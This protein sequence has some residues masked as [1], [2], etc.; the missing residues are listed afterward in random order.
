MGPQ[1][2]QDAVSKPTNTELNHGDVFLPRGR[3]SPCSETAQGQLIAFQLRLHSFLTS[4]I[5][6]GH[7]FSGCIFQRIGQ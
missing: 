3:A 6:Q 4:S 7:I 5:P 2:T 1:D